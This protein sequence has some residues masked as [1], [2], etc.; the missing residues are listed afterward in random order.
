MS[1]SGCDALDLE[2]AVVLAADRVRRIDRGHSA[3]DVEP[4]ARDRVVPARRRL[5]RSQREH[6]QQVVLH[7]VADRPDAV[8]ERAAAL[9]AEVLGERDLDR[10]DVLPAPH[11]LE[12]GVREAEVH[13]V[14]HRL[15]AQEVVDP[16]DP[17]LG[18]DRGQARVELPRGVEVGAERLLDH[19]PRVLRERGGREPFGN[20]PEVVGR[21]REVEHRRLR[22]PER[23]LDP[24][25][26]LRVGGVAADVGQ[27]PEEILEHVLVD[28][29]DRLL[30]R[31]ACQLPQLVLA[32]RPPPDGHHRAR[33]V[34]LLGEAV[35]RGQRH[36]AREVAGDAEHDERV[37]L[38]HESHPRR[39]TSS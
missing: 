25:V 10:L 22:F 30:D 18:E 35:E 7:D 8:V 3:E 16:E 4:P 13:D 17:L 29:V 38:G 34:L 14:L 32:E 26:E 6:L 27:P 11:R 2:V 39:V 9:D 24:L 1:E 12:E 28:V 37:G 19:E 21:D 20:R 36:P 31:V 15:L 23:L 5:H 33:E